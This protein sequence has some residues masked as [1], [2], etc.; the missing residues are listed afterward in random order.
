[1]SV[2]LYRLCSLPSSGN[3]KETGEWDRVV[4]GESDKK[5]LDISIPFYDVKKLTFL[6]WVSERPDRLARNIRAM[7]QLLS[8]L[9]D[10]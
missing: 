6:G 7:I 4:F 8:G 9:D 3:V 1:M 2:C 10:L 5:E